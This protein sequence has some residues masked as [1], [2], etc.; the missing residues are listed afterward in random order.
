MVAV[1]LIVKYV[2]FSIGPIDSSFVNSDS[3]R[4]TLICEM[5]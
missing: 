1:E 2:R 3:M 5:L 4:G